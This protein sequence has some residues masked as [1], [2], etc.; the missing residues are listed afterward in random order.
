[1]KKFKLL[2]VLFSAMLVLAA[3]GS[4]ESSSEPKDNGT[5][6]K[7]EKVSITWKFGH[8]ANEDHLWHK[9]ALKFSELVSEKTDQPT[10][11]GNRYN[12]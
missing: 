2:S 9:T 4:D 10:W 1:M 7:E 11:W 5:P 8:L 3:C 12:Q 6:A